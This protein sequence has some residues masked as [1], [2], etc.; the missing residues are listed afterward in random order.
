MY[1][2]CQTKKLKPRN[3]IKQE[4]RLNKSDKKSYDS[5]IQV[6]DFCCVGEACRNK[7]KD[8]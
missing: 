7:N 8:A 2:R 3:E 5:S 1:I 6:I 4:D